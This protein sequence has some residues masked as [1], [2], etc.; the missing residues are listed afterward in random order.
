[1]QTALYAGGIE[2]DAQAPNA[3]KATLLNAPNNVPIVN[4]VTPNAS[5]LSHNKFTDFN[6]DN[7]GLILN[8]S[9]VITNT[10]LSGYISYNPN[11]TGSEAKL[12]LNEV[13]STNKTLLQGYTEVAGKSADVII[14]NPNGISVNGG[15][16]INTPN[17]T[18]TTGTPMLNGGILQGFDVSKGNIIIEGNGFNSNNID[19]VNLYAKAL[20]L[21]AKIYA[22]ELNVVTGENNISQDGTVTSKNQNGSGIAIDSTLLGGIYANTITLKSTDKGVGVNLPPEVIAQDNLKLNAD[23]KIVLDKVISEKNIDIKS[24]SSDITSK[25]IYAQN[26]NI[27]AKGN[28]RNENIIAS[29]VNIDLKAKSIVNENTIASGVTEELKDSITGTLTIN[30]EELENKKTLYAKDNIDIKSTII[31]SNNSN[32]QALGGINIISDKLQSQ[33]S[34]IFANKNIFLEGEDVI[35]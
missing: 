22:N 30:S 33:D 7:K 8:N 5:G 1:E 31:T 13:T 26:V 34:F 11:L 21:N 6:V 19:K 29:K 23:G 32:I 17:A 20:E 14:A 28:I 9:K 4:I 35:L 15:G 16:F 25:T 10:Q 24:T 27:E 3:N 12:I 18:L 2:V